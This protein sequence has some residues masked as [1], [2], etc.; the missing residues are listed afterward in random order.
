MDTLANELILLIFNFIKL[1]TDKRQFLRTCV[2]YNKITKGSMAKFE[3]SY[4]IK[5]FKKINYYC[6]E[7][8]TL[9][10]CHD[11]YF[12]MIPKSYIVENNY[13]IGKA[14][15]AFYDE[16]LLYEKSNRLIDYCKYAFVLFIESLIEYNKPNILEL[17]KTNGCNLEKI[18]KYAAKHGNIYCLE[19]ESIYRRI[20]YIFN[21]REGLGHKI[22]C[23]CLHAAENGHLNILK[24]TNENGCFCPD[25]FTSDIAAK[26]GHL[27][28]LKWFD[29]NGFDWNHNICSNAALGGQLEIL[30]WAR[31][32]DFYWDESTCANAA[33]Y[34]HLECLIWAYENGCEWNSSTCAEA[35]RSGHLVILKWAREN[36]C[37]WNVNTCILAANYGHL[38]CLIW[39]RE[40]GCDW[41]EMVTQYARSNGHFAVLNWALENGC[42]E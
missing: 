24:W 14:L 39:A 23:I 10:L 27:H 41:N 17:A 8:F 30:K 35:A 18:C 33:K 42:P 9:E 6:M 25:L 13:I 1:I 7:K 16:E 4:S 26:N 22:N 20:Y 34:G 36:G 2:T 15:G 37:V 11:K 29:E 32:K 5:H 38:E 21:V 40:N 3:N 19:E 28:I 31:E 12:D